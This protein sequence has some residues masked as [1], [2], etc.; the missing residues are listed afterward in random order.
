MTPTLVYRQHS[1]AQE[2][3]AIKQFIVRNTVDAS[4]VRDL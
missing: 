2:K 1:T 3:E 4:V